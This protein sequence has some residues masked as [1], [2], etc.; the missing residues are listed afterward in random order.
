MRNA[1][2]VKQFCRSLAGL[3]ASIA[4]FAE[5]IDEFLLSHGYPEDYRQIEAIRGGLEDLGLY[6][7]VLGAVKQSE[8]LVREGKYDEAE[9]LVL[10]MNRKLS[11]ASGAE[12]DLRKM[13]KAANE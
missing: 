10:E 12:D 1:K 3:Q 13:Y 8:V 4:T 7:E 5:G 6:E 9:M 2:A 11:K